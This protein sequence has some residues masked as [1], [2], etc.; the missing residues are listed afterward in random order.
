M[1]NLV[2]ALLGILAIGAAVPPSAH[3][4][5]VSEVQTGRGPRFLYAL[6]NASK[7]RVVDA[8]SVP[9]LRRR[10]TLNFE[11][12]ER[13]KALA[14]VAKAA[15]LE[16]VYSDNVLPADGRVRL[17]AEEITVAAALT[18]VLLDA[19]VDV[20]LSPNG[21][22]VLVKRDAPK[23][24]APTGMISGRVIDS[25]GRQAIAGAL[26]GI[27]GTTRRVLTDDRGHYL[28]SGL[29]PGVR[30][31][32]V[33][34][35]G[36]KSQSVTL[37]LREAQDTTVNFVLFGAPSMLSD[38]VTTGSG[39]RERLTVG[40]SIASIKADS[41][42]ANNSI[43]NLSDLLAN[44][45]PGL[46]VVSGTGSVGSPSRIRIR[47]INSI[48]SS[49][50]PI[51]IIDGMRMATNYTTCL[52]AS[53]A[54][55]ASLPS[56]IDDIDPNIIESIEVMKGP[57]ASALW[58][59]DAANGVIVI[60]TKRGHAGPTRWTLLADQGFAFVST[61]FRVP[62]QGLGQAV[63]GGAIRRCTFI[64]QAQGLCVPVDSV[65]GGFN[66]YSN[67]RTTGVAT[68]RTGA[69]AV[70]VS[71]GVS[72]VQ[73]Y[74]STGYKTQL[75]VTKLP[76][77]DQ[78]IIQETIGGPLP[79]WMKRPNSQT[80]ANFNGRITGQLGTKADYAIGANFIQLFQRNGPDPIQHGYADLRSAADTFTVSSGWNQAVVERK[81]NVTRFLGNFTG[82]W[83][84]T[85]WLTATGTV[86]R[87]YAFGS[88]N[89]LLRRNW[90]IEAILCG[91]PLGVVRVGATQTFVQTGNLGV[92]LNIPVRSSAMFR[93]AIGAQY[94]QTK[95]HEFNGSAEDLPL[96]RTDL[97]FARGAKTVQES[98]DDRATYGTY[99]D[100]S[101][102]FRDRVFLSAAAR[103]DLGSALG[104]GV[105]PIFPKWSVS[106]LVSEE[107]LFPWKD[108]G[109]RF[110]LR[111]AFGHA[112]VQ[113]SSVAK[114]R[115]YDQVA[116]FVNP[117]GSFGTN[118]TTLS[119]LGN[120]E[121]RPERSIERE[122][123][124]ELGFWD[125]RVT[126][127]FTAFRKFSEDAIISRPVAPS[128]GLSS[129]ATQSF[130]IGNVL[131]KGTEATV[132]AVLIDRSM[133][134]W[135]VR[136]GYASRRNK[137]VTLGKNIPWFTVSGVPLETL[138]ADHA[139]VREGYPLFG[140]WAKPIIGYSDMNGDGI[141]T[142]SEVKMGDSLVFV[143]PSEPK[144]DIGI[145]QDLGIWNDRIHIGADL[146]YVIGQTQ[147]NTYAAYTGFYTIDRYRASTPLQ[148]Q[149]CIAA[150]E[151]Q[152][153]YCYFETVNSLR[154]RNLSIGYTAPNRI[155]S[156]FRAQS[157]AFSLLASNLAVW[158]KYHGIDPGLNT[159]A[160]GGNLSFS[161]PAL[162]QPRTFTVRG[163]IT[164]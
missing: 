15:G 37:T 7:P 155:A 48:N 144:A 114:Y 100:Q 4:Q 145:R 127:D 99:V 25:A 70:D 57:A 136:L 98:S 84:P 133:L 45:A 134:R 149:A 49:N 54:G 10:I 41:I 3:A 53:L 119:G 162:P 143:G 31:V 111:S 24:P 46:E 103:R 160:A 79:G 163:R 107:P 124:F 69:F 43:L 109:V 12:L 146:Q 52:N 33:R 80:N 88:A 44:R 58:G 148:T 106:W 39:E 86:G 8:A 158:S 19:G 72:A 130:N 138:N 23:A 115:S 65:L 93:T 128:L 139:V 30:T 16:L 102:A 140:R 105:A 154:L 17:V 118:F 20:V 94:A 83:R 66:R 67:S 156:L 35:L 76:D 51:I 56:R 164:F 122:G 125:E 117:D 159:A 75:G 121:L 36:F 90:C 89:E 60:K 18:E 40:N 26:V 27:S 82:H 5:T 74:F 101:V 113:P 147:L 6:P 97:N 11:G 120:A 21:S 91:N 34:R 14:A 151:K 152:Y 157:V 28:L 73:Y 68:G 112:G 32:Y 137:L 132:S 61:D 2:V 116:R 64:D 59:A 78:K 123:G 161:G 55:C 63:N 85:S 135:S 92:A 81:Q 95:S 9:L 1:R 50:D 13:R 153:D 29:E 38:V 126:L 47:G 110:R 96:G 142:F 42:V 104:T 131:N 62:V 141:I 77:V 22:A 108:R 87:D 129:S 71:G 150:A